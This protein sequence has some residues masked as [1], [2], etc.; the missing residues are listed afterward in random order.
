M[1][2]VK[3]LRIKEINKTTVLLENNIKA[4]Y[5][6]KTQELKK[7]DL[8]LVFGNLVIEKIEARNEK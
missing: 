2:F 7:N 5:N 1:C 4:Y 3:P 6:V 8:V